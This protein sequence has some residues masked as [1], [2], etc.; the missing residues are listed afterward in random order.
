MLLQPKISTHYYAQTYRQGYDYACSMF[1]GR[2]VVDLIDTSGDQDVNIADLLIHEKLASPAT[3]NGSDGNRDRIQKTFVKNSQLHYVPGWGADRTVR[4][5]VELVNSP[6]YHSLVVFPHS[7]YFWLLFWLF[8]K[9][10]FYSS[11]PLNNN[12]LVLQIQNVKG[13]VCI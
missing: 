8:S 5:R 7:P 4:S 11:L 6:H 12:S 9:V 1:T 13:I 10:R 3:E 2:L